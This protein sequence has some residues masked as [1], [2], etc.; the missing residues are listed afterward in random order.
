MRRR[1]RGF[2]LLETVLALTLLATLL[3]A[4]YGGLRTGLQSWEAGLARSARADDLLLSTGFLRREIASAF[5]WRLKDPMAVRLAFIGERDRLRLVSQRPAEIAGGG[6][7]FVAFAFESGGTGPGRLAMRRALAAADATDLSPLD[8]AEAFTLLA[9]V[10]A[11]RF[12]Y[13]G[14]DADPEPAD[15]AGPVDRHAAP[16]VPRAHRPSS[17][18]SASSRR[19]SSPCGWAR[20]PVA[21]NRCSS[22]NACRAD[23]AP[24][25]AGRRLVLVISVVT[26]LAI[27]AGSF[28]YSVRTDARAARNAALGR[29]GRGHR[30]GRHRPHGH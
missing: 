27:A 12:Q 15:L 19:S 14:T 13:Y 25:P 26:L 21:T 3:A 7:A 20:R 2:T 23:E 28:A 16:A 29:P 18:A 24:I 6:L 17:W 4:L 30:A 8:S 22:A 11:A 10:T 1:A 9:G 5:P